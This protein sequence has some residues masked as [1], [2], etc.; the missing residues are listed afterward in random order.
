MLTNN[1]FLCFSL[2]ISYN[3]LCTY[4]ILGAVLRNLGMVDSWLLKIGISDAFTR[5]QNSV[6]LTELDTWETKSELHWKPQNNELLEIT[7]VFLVMIN[8]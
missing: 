1:S 2:Y 5:C 3:I 6:D 4:H 8:G 7:S